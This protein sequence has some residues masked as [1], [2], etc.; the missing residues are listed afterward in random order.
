MLLYTRQYRL[1]DPPIN[2]TIAVP[3]DRNLL[4]VNASPPHSTLRISHHLGPA[5]LQ[6][7]PIPFLW[8]Q[9]R[10][11][12]DTR[13][14]PVANL[15]VVVGTPCEQVPPVPTRSRTC[16][17]FECEQHMPVWRHRERMGRNRLQVICFLRDCQVFQMPISLLTGRVRFFGKNVHSNSPLTAFVRT[18]TF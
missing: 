14:P 5:L 8:F 13:T 7:D 1:S 3:S 11:H 16:M 4:N 15:I 10:R 2:Q 17:R 18:G 12:C 6:H 9:C